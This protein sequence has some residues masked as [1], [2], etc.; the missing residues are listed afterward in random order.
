M[1]IYMALKS[2]KLRYNYN[3]CDLK[4]CNSRVSVKIGFIVSKWQ[5]LQ[6]KCCPV[7]KQK[8]WISGVCWKWLY[9]S[10]NTGVATILYTSPFYLKGGLSVSFDVIMTSPSPVNQWAIPY[11][12][13]LAK[14]TIHCV[15]LEIY[16]I[17]KCFLF[18][19]TMCK[20]CW[21]HL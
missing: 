19:Y 1:K 9:C 15:K 20:K 21:K 7:L 17:I 2:I 5:V 18:F 3:V 6:I 12:I 11:R 8:V 4:W 16:L 13:L 14:I 10:K